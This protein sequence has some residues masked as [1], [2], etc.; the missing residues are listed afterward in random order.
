L[1]GEIPPSSSEEDR[2]KA[3][4]DY[5][6]KYLASLPKSK[7]EEIIITE[8]KNKFQLNTAQISNVKQFYKEESKL[9][10]GEI[11]DLI[12]KKLS[13]FTMEDTKEIYVYR[14]GVYNNK[15]SMAKLGTIIR[16][17]SKDYG[18]LASTAF[19][20]E[21]IAYIQAYTFVDREYVDKGQYIN[22]SNGLFN[23][24]TWELE[25]H[26]KDYYS[27]RQIPVDYD[28]AATCPNIEK[29]LSEVVDP[30]NI[31][32][33]YEW[34]GLSLIPDTKF[35]KALMLY[36]KGGNGKTVFLNLFVKFLGI[37]NIARESLQKLETDKYS[38]ANLYGKLMNICPDIPS[39]TLHTTDIFKQL[40]GDDHF[41]RG[42]RKY[43][44]A[45]SFKNT[46]RL[47]FSANQLPKGN[48]DYAFSRRW[49][50]I[51][52]P[53]SF[54]NNQDKELDNKLTPELTG[55]LNLALTGLKRLQENGKFSNSK[56]V[57]DTQKEYLINCDPVRMFL[58]ECTELTDDTVSHDDMYEYY[59]LWAEQNKIPVLKENPFCKQM[60]SNGVSSHRINGF[61][62]KTQ[63]IRKISHFVGVALK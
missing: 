62:E 21:V 42:E 29:F 57:D 8:L 1:E 16:E 5:V 19:V 14:K 51:N 47:T 44:D 18:H 55:L 22:F 37:E 11:G 32:L 35:Q 26:R 59:E 58:D 12:L 24:S 6:K 2:L 10:F 50:L 41:I 49:I 39:N 27:I 36:G 34:I 25:G 56:S 13:I 45:F 63:R 15:G 33:L 61:D 54:E 7:A 3:S 38:V 40:A 53:N 46:A 4:K 20:N 31:P 52:F 30:E 43:Q 9:S 48:I 60:K 28:P 17:V 23:L